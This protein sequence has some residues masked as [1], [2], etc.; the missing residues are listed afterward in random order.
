MRGKGGWGN[1]SE[2]K[3]GVEKKTFAEKIVKTD[4]QGKNPGGGRYSNCVGQ[5]R[6]G[7]GRPDKKTLCWKRASWPQT[8]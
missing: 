4:L 3:T 8:D 7:E 6:R 1:I 5:G 2:I